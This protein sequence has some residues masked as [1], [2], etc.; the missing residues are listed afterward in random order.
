MKSNR[1][2]RHMGF[3]TSALAAGGAVIALAAS[4]ATA[5][6]QSPLRDGNSSPDLSATPGV[7]APGPQQS[8]PQLARPPSMPGTTTSQKLGNSNGV[9]S[10]PGQMDPGIH[11]DAP[12]RADFPMPIVPPPGT[13]GGNPNVIS[14]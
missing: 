4:V 3:R 11:K 12:P 8:T 9:I 6:A 13:P 5:S 7:N 1:K 14:K 2:M 10:P